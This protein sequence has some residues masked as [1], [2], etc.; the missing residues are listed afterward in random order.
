VVP[1]RISGTIADSDSGVKPGSAEYAV[2]DEYHLIEP[3]G[4]VGL[5]LSGNYSFTLMLR[6]SREDEDADG[7][8]YTVRVSARDNAGNRGVNWTRVVVPHRD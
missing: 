3:N 1:V 7:R 6:A 8:H 5:D 4:K 2:Q